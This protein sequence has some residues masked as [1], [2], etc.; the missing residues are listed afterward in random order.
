MSLDQ[1][2]YLYST[3]IFSLSMDTEKECI[4]SIKTGLDTFLA[5]STL[6]DSVLH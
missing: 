4:L 2:N 3:P 5:L 1:E 6:E